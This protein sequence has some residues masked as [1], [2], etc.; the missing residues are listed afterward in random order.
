MTTQNIISP[1]IRMS[2][3]LPILTAKDLGIPSIQAKL[4]KLY[5]NTHNLPTNTSEAR[6]IDYSFTETPKIFYGSVAY[7]YNKEANEQNRLL[8][9]KRKLQKALKTKLT[10]DI[11]K[12]SDTNPIKLD[13]H[14]LVGSLGDKETIKLLLTKLGNII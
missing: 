1:N 12:L 13:L 8:I 2:R 9:I 5:K 3:L 6:L 11:K 10:R 14:R 7:D 4:R